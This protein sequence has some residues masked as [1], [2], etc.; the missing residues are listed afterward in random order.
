M[1]ALTALKVGTQKSLSFRGRASRSEYWWF[2]AW[3]WAIFFVVAT[4]GQYI[5]PYLSSISQVTNFLLNIL[6]V[7]MVVSNSAAG[8]RRLHDSGLSGFHYFVPL[9]FTLVAAFFLISSLAAILVGPGAEAAN[10]IAGEA[11]VAWIVFRAVFGLALFIS[12]VMLLWR[13]RKVS[14]LGTNKYGPNPHEVQS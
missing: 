7:W 9:A 1:N 3:Q 11:L 4:I 14:Q 5:N 6:L 10:P 8:F 12:W 13:L 2:T